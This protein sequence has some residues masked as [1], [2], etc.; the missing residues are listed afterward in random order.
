MGRVL[1]ARQG[2]TQ[3]TAM[4]TPPAAVT[5]PGIP[6]CRGPFVC[7]LEWLPWRDSLGG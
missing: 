1:T 4:G 3:P 7:V 5:G 6:K 2:E